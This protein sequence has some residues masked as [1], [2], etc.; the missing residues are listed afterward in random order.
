MPGN[1][2]FQIYD[3]IARAHIS[4]D[5]LGIGLCTGTRPAPYTPVGP[6]P[7][8]VAPWKPDQVEERMAYIFDRTSKE[9][10]AMLNLWVLP[11]PDVWWSALRKWITP[12]GF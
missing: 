6:D 10:P 1:I 4:P 2:S 7:C 8:A 12:K 5:R 9:L 11:V 3:Q